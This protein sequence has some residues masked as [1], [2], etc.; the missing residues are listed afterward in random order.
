VQEEGP[1]ERYFY[2]RRDVL[3]CV[4]NHGI[5]RGHLTI[6]G[7]QH[8]MDG[9]PGTIAI[10]PSG[11]AF[12]TKLE[13]TISSTHLYLR[14][15]LIDQVAC[16]LYGEDS[17]RVDIPL[18]AAKYDPVLEHLCH[19]VRQT[20]DD[21]DDADCA[22]YVEHLLKAIVA[23]LLRN[24]PARDIDACENNGKLSEKQLRLV[25]E[26]IE[27][28]IGDRLVLADIA[29]HFGF[30]SDH[31]GRLFKNTTGLTLYQFVIRCRI[32][33]AR[34]LLA[35]TDMSIAMIA[36]ECGFADQVHLTRA[37]RRQTGITPAAYRKSA[38]A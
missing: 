6:N 19:A 20:L 26:L 2:A 4:V 32:D 16:K 27:A 18:C 14:R 5:L 13:T 12:G 1:H 15:S 23:Y 33:R 36:Q 9:G 30:S 28:R 10:I 11:L 29:C 3:I 38:A 25:S 31:F 17:A 8:S 24:H 22:P 7:R 34:H 35:D 37:M 21:P